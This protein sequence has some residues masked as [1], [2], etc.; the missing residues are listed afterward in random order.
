MNFDNF[1]SLIH[2]SWHSKLRKWIESSE[3]DE[4]Y[5]FLKNE[6]KRGRVIA[7]LSSNVWRAFKETPYDGLKVILVGMAP[8]HTFKD[9]KPIADGLLMSCSVTGKLQPSLSNFYDAM[10]KELYQGFSAHIIKDPNL[11][12]LANQG[13]LLLNAS[14]STEK[15]KAG[16]HMEI[17]SGFMKYLFEKVLDVTGAPVVFLG[18]DAARY[19]RYVSPFTWQFTVSHP[20]SSSYNGNDWCSEDIFKKLNKIL[21]ESF[22]TKIKWALTNED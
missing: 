16:S 12:Y 4:V 7:P 1:S 8:Y 13:V 22:G 2:P 14:L 15:D 18:Q 19:S 11:Q 9:G 5:A 10:E 3:C 21:K 20:A 17:W 6:S